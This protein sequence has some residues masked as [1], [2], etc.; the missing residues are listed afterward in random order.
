MTDGAS[1]TRPRE[2]AARRE[3]LLLRSAQLREQIGARTQVLRP[4]FRAVD[5]VRGGARAVRSNRGWVLL[6]AAAWPAPRW[7]GHAWCWDWAHGRGPA[8]RRIGA[9]SRSRARCCAS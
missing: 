6:G 4:A 3:H 5:R 2:L 7:C 9:C 8:G 1:H